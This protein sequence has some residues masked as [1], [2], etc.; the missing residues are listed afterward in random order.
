[1]PRGIPNQNPKVI[2]TLTRQQRDLFEDLKRRLWARTNSDALE[3]L[4][5]AAGLLRETVG[6]WDELATQI[7]EVI[8][9]GTDTE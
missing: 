7:H 1:M 2:I 4:M 6:T 5:V 9:E 3:A 8:V